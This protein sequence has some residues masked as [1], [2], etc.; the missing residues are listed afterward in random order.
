MQTCEHCGVEKHGLL[1]MTDCDRRNG[2]T[3]SPDFVRTRIYR[4][5]NHKHCLNANGNIQKDLDYNNQGITTEQWLETAKAI[6]E[7]RF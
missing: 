2:T 4:N 6:A 1:F 3:S 7:K 5:L